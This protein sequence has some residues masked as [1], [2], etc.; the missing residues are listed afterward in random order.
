MQVSLLFNPLLLR[1]VCVG[2]DGTFA[3]VVNGLLIR[4]QK[5]H[6]IDVNNVNASLIPPNLRVGVIPAG[7]LPY[8]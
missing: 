1:I 5:S 3:E 2:G 4:T 7:E 6:G 8:I